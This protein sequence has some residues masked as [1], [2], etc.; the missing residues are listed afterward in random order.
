MVDPHDAK[1]GEALAEVGYP[2]SIVD[3]ARR[4]YWSDFKSPL[5]LPKME[6]AGML[7][8]DGHIELRKRVIAGE[9]D[10]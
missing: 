2:Q 10:G 5:A 6:L 7:E 8:C 4:G 3:Q 1:L 9:F